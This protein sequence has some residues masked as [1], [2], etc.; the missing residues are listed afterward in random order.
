MARKNKHKNE[1]LV[2]TD[3]KNMFPTNV[4]YEGFA[5][6]HKDADS[7]LS[8]EFHSSVYEKNHKLCEVLGM[9]DDETKSL[10][11]RMT[12]FYYWS[13]S[14]EIYE[15]DTDFAK[16]LMQTPVEV[17]PYQSLSR[18]P[19]VTFAI[20][21]GDEYIIVHKGYDKNHVE[22]DYLFVAHCSHKTEYVNVTGFPL[23][24]TFESID[25]FKSICKNPSQID[26]IIGCLNLIMY[27]CAEK[28]DIDPHPEQKTIT[29]RSSVTRNTYRE[30][31][32]WNVGHRFG[33]AYRKHKV[34]SQG[35]GVSVQSP[36]SS[37]TAQ[38]SV[39]PHIRRAHW[40]RFWTGT[41]ENKHLALKWLS[42][43]TINADSEQDLPA[44]IHKT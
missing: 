35:S 23:H 25:A 8:E 2:L 42:P 19:Y 13:K 7:K 9:H 17:I 44:V 30:I 29:K 22:S 33:A 43:M 31:R 24:E 12:L 15:F 6:V 40:H 11:I 21:L 41:G 18:L 38:R 36:S 27:L 34:N 28:P 14:K 16:I 37:D 3:L 39:R 1:P 32:K 20:S 5:K 26:D 10:L 4:S